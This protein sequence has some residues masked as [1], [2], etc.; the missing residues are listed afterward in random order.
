MTVKLINN[1]RSDRIYDTTLKIT[2]DKGKTI[3]IDI[4]FDRKANYKL[5]LDSTQFEND[6]IDMLKFVTD[7]KI[8]IE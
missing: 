2:N 1:S 7:D 6:L 8:Q 5:G 3:F 4:M